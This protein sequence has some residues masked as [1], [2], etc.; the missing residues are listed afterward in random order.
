MATKVWTSEEVDALSKQMGGGDKVKRKPDDFPKASS[1]W[2]AKLQPLFP[3]DDKNNVWTVR[4]SFKIIPLLFD[5]TSTMT[6]NELKTCKRPGEK[7][8]KH[9][10]YSPGSFLSFFSTLVALV[11]RESSN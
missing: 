6:I 9:I 10:L 4:G 1:V 5:V 8:L 7:M 3:D 11:A 2:R